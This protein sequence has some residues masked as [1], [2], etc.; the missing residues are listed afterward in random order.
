MKK[1]LLISFIILILLAAGGTSAGVYYYMQYQ[2]L[3]ARTNDPNLAAKDV[4][5][6]VGKLIE[7]P[8]GEQPTIA[9]VTNP[10][11]LNG[12]AFFAKAKK[13]DRVILYSTAKLAILYDE[14]AN[15]IINFGTINPSAATPSGAVA[16]ATSPKPAP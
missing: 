3:L 12:Q 15:K 2:H 16:P 7:L 8:T 10:D 5:D 6:K 11:L 14:T 9:T 4:L 13:G 1:S